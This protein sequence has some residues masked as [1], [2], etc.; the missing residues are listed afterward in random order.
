MTMQEQLFQMNYSRW[1]A[2]DSCRKQY[3]FSYLS[4]MAWPDDIESAP[5]IVGKAVHEGMKYLADTGDEEM[6]RHRMEKYLAMPSHQVAGPGT[7]NYRMAMEYY[8]NGCAAHRSIESVDCWTEL[9]SWRHFKDFG[10][11]LFARLDRVDK[12]A[13]D[14][15]LVIDWKTG[16]YLPSTDTDL[17]LDIA[18][19][20][21]RVTRPQLGSSG[22]VDAIAWSLRTGEQRIR[23]LTV[24][25]AVQTGRLFGR[26]AARIQKEE[27]FEASP[28]PQCNFCKW[29]PQCTAAEDAVSGPL[30]PEFA[31]DDFEET[32]LLPEDYWKP[33][34]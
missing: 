21:T 5:G 23:R 32:D 34:A 7:D 33:D 26:I 12:I 8:E 16:R 19:T 6:G 24:Q 18:H 31:E 29:R 27:E 9:S 10:V 1:K 25:D 13:A 22:V 20:I 15:Y 11:R 28:G 3:W 2:W 30:P 4:G 17:Q 14:H